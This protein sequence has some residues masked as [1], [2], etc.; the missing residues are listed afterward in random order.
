MGS[1][2]LDMLGANRCMRHCAHKHA[3]AET[4][5]MVAAETHVHAAVRK[6]AHMHLRI[7]THQCIFHA[8][9]CMQLHIAHI[10][11]IAISL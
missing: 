10:S 9:A 7:V 4:A 8:Q 11:G 6:Q 1:P 2:V 3:T 5:S